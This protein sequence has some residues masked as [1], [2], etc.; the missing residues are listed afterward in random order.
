MSRSLAPLRFDVR[1][2]REGD[3][4]RVLE[5][6]RSAL[7]AGPTGSRSSEF[8]RWKHEQNP[9]GRSLMLVAE[10]D[11]RIIGLRAFM[12]WRFVA[13]ERVVDAARPVDTATHPEAQGR[14]VFS[15]LT[16]EGLAALDGSVGLLFNTPN[17]KS[18]PGYLKMGWRP[19]GSVPISFRVRRPVRFARGLPSIRADKVAPDGAPPRVDAGSAAEALTDVGAVS[20]LLDA[21]P[22]A[23][24]LLSTPKSLAYLR[25]R[26]AAVPMLDYRA[27][28]IE[29]AGRLAALAFF[30]VRPRGRL[31]ETTIAD[32]LV[33]EGDR[34]TMRRLLRAV[35]RA[36]PVDVLTCHVA[37]ASA[38][39]P[40][41]RR[42][43]FLRSPVG[44]TFVVRAVASDIC[45]DPTRLSSWSLSLG[46][47]E[48]F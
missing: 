45:P 39:A 8:F 12:R 33:R 2:Y 26:Y 34:P 38:A 17:D 10:Q 20:E 11:D 43:G 46:D 35:L 25:W 4:G 5:L 9:F 40:I 7:G 32:L 16:K 31:W 27:V 21:L 14:G 44:M 13:G 36:A 18:L 29:D 19:A 28:R 47:L 37:R 42:S 3:E 30:R 22:S 23:G 24:H 6:L 1:P 41:M 48:V 15:H